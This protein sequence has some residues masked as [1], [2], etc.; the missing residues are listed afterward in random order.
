MR[1]EDVAGLLAAERSIAPA[2]SA[3][4]RICRRR[5]RAACG[6]RRARARLRG[7]CW[8]WWWRRRDPWRSSR[9]ACMSR[10]AS[11]M[12]A[13]PLTT[14][15]WASASMA[16]SASPSKVTPRSAPSDFGFRGDNCR[17]AARRS[18]SLMLRPSGDACVRW[19]VPPR[20][21]KSSGAMAEAAP[22]AQSNNDLRPLRVRPGTAATQETARSRRGYLSFDGGRR[23]GLGS[24]LDLPRR[25]KISVFDAKLSIVGQFEAVAAEDLDAI[26]LPG[27]VG[28]GDDDACRR[29]HV[30]ARGKRW[31]GW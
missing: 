25:R 9:A 23:A 16:R 20:C 21:A 8:T 26:V 27:I 28:G 7:P 24:D 5:A 4:A 18:P 31:R 1:E 6:C 19:M 15:P 2:A 13:S 29:S 17:D 11:N 14:L 22:L 3:R 12:T 30:C 10:A